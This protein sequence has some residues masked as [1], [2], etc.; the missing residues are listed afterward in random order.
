MY[1]HARFA[2]VCVRAA[3]HHE[4]AHHDGEEEAEQHPINHVLVR[5]LLRP[6]LL[7]LARLALADLSVCLWRHILDVGLDPLLLQT[8][9]GGGICIWDQT[10]RKIGTV[11]EKASHLH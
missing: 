11:R 7:R 1:L 6:P 4:K 5:P 2:C 8:M 9:N 10:A 3:P